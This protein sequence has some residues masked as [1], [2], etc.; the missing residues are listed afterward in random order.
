MATPLDI[1]FPLNEKRFYDAD[2]LIIFTTSCEIR[3]DQ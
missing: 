2:L 3:L 1:L